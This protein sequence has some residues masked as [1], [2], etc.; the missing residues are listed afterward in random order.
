MKISKKKPFRKRKLWRGKNVINVN[1]FYYCQ[2][3]GEREERESKTF[4]FFRPKLC[5]I[6]FVLDLSF[7]KVCVIFFGWRWRICLGIISI[8]RNLELFMMFFLGIQFSCKQSPA[9]LYDRPKIGFI[10]FKECF[11]NICSYNVLRYPL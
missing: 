7:D 11:T 1:R 4:Y 9:R 2:T 10:K 8:E 3:H 5:G 6:F